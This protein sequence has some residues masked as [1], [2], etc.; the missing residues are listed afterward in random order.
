MSLRWRISHFRRYRGSLNLYKELSIYRTGDRISE[1]VKN[2][3][4]NP[5]L[6]LLFRSIIPKDADPKFFEY[7]RTLDCSK[8]KI[9]AMK[10]GGICFPNEPLLSIEGPQSVV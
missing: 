1:I 7:L 3:Q 9:R 10:E 6:K 8:V 4:I 5:I 2:K